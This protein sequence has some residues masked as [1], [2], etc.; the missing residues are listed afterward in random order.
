MSWQNFP[1][2]KLHIELSSYCNAACPLCP[3]FISNS[4][5][6]RKDLIQAQISFEKFKEY[7]PVSV[8]ENLDKV[9]YCGTM[10]DPITNKEI[11]QIVEYVTKL[12]PNCE[13]VIHTNGGI[14]SQNFWQQLGKIFNTSNRKVTFSIDGL[15]DTNHLYRRN[16]V[17]KKLITNVKNFIQSGGHAR[18]EYLVFKHNE[19]QIETARKLCNDLGFKLFLDKKPFGFINYSNNTAVNRTVFDKDGQPNYTL[20]PSTIQYYNNGIAV[21]KNTE[22]YDPD[23]S[24]KNTTIESLGNYAIALDQQQIR[25]ASLQ[26]RVSEVYVNSQGFVFPCCYVGTSYDGNVDNFLDYQIKFNIDQHKKLLDLNKQN[27]QE[28]M[29]EGIID[30]IFSSKWKDKICD[31]KIGFCSQTCG[32]TNPVDKIYQH[33]V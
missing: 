15:E 14:R 5:N 27:I 33:T 29:Q 6:I 31:G 20:E 8:L 32:K 17:W 26:N 30:R 1:L 3:R 24:I 7:F 28:I 21:G 10:G 11:L 4:P 18:W 23:R 19:H 13:Q 22:V 16:V 9:L 25:C 12:N 2:K